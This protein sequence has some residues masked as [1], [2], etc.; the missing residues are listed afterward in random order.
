MSEIRNPMSWLNPKDHPAG[1]RWLVRFDSEVGHTGVDIEAEVVRWQS[2][3]WV[4]LRINGRKESSVWNA[5]SV[6][7][8][9]KAG[10]V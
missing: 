3:E 10:D 4:R 7:V 8:I 1:T 2:S 5:S 9:G 6:E